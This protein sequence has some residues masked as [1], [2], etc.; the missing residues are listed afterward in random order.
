MIFL[1]GKKFAQNEKEVVESLFD[2]T[3]TVD[4]FC[5]IHKRKILFMNLQKEPIAFVNQH[6]VLGNAFVH[7]EKI[8]YQAGIP[9]DHLLYC[10]SLLKIHD[11]ISRLACGCDEGGVFFK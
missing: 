5:K 9:E 4:G 3:G 6:K 11:E 7:N 2:P 1:L 10:D 8:Y